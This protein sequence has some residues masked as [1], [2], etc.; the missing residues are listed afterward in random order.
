MCLSPFTVPNP[1]YG[2]DPSKGFNYL[3]DCVS[4]QM[5]V[6]CGHCPVC[7]ALKQ[8]Y[9]V[10]RCQCEN[11]GNY[12]YFVTLTYN[13]KSI[14]KLNVN[15][16]SLKYADFRDI[17]LM[18]K[19]IRNNNLFGRPFRFWCVSEYGGEKHRPH[20]HM[21]ISIPKYDTDNKHSPFLLEKKLHDVILSNWVRNVG[22]RRKP[23]Y[24]PLCTYIVTPKGRTFDC[25]FIRSEATKEGEADV[26]FYV[27]KY[28][29]KY[30]KYVDSL[31]S[32]LKL[33][34]DPEEFSEVW[35]LLK[36]RSVQSRNWAD[37]ENPKVIEHVRKGIDY[38]VK[39]STLLYPIFINPVN[40]ST[41]PLSPYLKKKFLTLDDAHSF[42]FKYEGDK[43]VFHHL[44]EVEK[45][46]DVDTKFLKFIQNMDYLSDREDCL[47]D[48]LDY[49]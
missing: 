4:Q 36:P 42:F 37:V 40:G 18:F 33:N 32:A 19:R 48:Y 6:P 9:F 10:Q 46:Q 2:H 15:G 8:S 31:H 29:C 3:H 14:R 43:S 49:D 44:D 23:V 21:I 20:F 45:V 35:K 41:F 11:F 28:M 5:T 17:R 26:A 30:S 47:T 25:H 16:Y 13:N 12:L 34:M 27:S 22:S 1:Y 38:A 39:D 7:I 24:V